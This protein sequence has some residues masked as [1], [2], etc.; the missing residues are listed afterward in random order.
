MHTFAYIVEFVSYTTH[1]IHVHT[2]VYTLYMRGLRT[3]DVV[4][5]MIIYQIRIATNFPFS[6]R[7]HT[8]RRSHTQSPAA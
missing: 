6:G 1:M 8:R 5:R 3:H 4:A 2:C 7:T